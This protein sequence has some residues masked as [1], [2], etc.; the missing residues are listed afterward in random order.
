MNASNKQGVRRRCRKSNQLERS[1]AE[2]Y[3]DLVNSG[4]PFRLFFPLGVLI[5]VLGVSMWPLHVWGVMD[6]YPGV[7]H[8][9]VMIEGFLTAFVMGFLGTALPRLLEVPKIRLAEAVSFTVVLVGVVVLHACGQSVLGD[10]L[11]IFMLGLFV[12]LL[13]LRALLFRRDVPPPGF[14]LVGMGLASAL[15][16]ASIQAISAALPEALPS[17][18]QTF[19]RLLL[20]QGYLLFPIMG[21]GAFLLPRFFGLPNR[22]SFPES[23]ALPPGWKRR[24]IFALACGLTVLL[25]FLAESLGHAQWGNALRAVGIITYFF[26]EVPFHKAGFGGGS[27]ALGLRIALILIPSAYVFMAVWPTRTFS[28]LHILFIGGFSLLTFIV[29]SRV[30]LGHSGQSD[31]FRA[32]LWPVLAMAF[33]VALAMLTRV[34]A[35]WMPETRLSH[36][37]YAALA[38]VIGAIIWAATILPGINKSDAE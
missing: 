37:A 18:L 10:Q 3:W 9:R 33:L 19:G 38:W 4:E 21:I 27:L 35:D 32:T 14:V 25:G 36:Y 29:A 23:L 12:V 26:R 22:Q 7:A 1:Q 8:S 16:G 2:G 6:K 11:F 34:S 15:V 30:V 31:K 5:G 17:W 28:L 24:A 20:H 13:G